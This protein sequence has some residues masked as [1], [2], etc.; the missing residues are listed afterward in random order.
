MKKYGLVCRIRQKK[1]KKRKQPHASI[2]NVLNRNFHADQPGEKFCIDIT[3]VEV[4]KSFKRWM[5]I[6]AVKDLYNNEIV[7]YH[8]STTQDMKLVLHTLYQLKEKGFVKGAILHS[9]QGFHSTN[10]TYIRTVANMSLTQSMSRRGNC[11]DSNKI[12]H[13]SSGI[14]NSCHIGHFFIRVYLTGTSSF[15]SAL[16]SLFL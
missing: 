15:E 7:A 12:R 2:S 14:P 5:Y 11:W 4:K 13:E 8:M 9:D 3:Y 10:P 6:C 1:F 16:C